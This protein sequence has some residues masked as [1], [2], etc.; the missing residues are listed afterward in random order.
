MDFSNH[1]VL[2]TGASRGVGAATARAFAQAGAK[3]VYLAARNTENLHK[4]QSEIEAMG[5]CA[6]AFTVDL[7]TREACRELAAK[8]GDIDVLVN[9]AAFTSGAD[10]NVLV[11][12]DEFWDLNFAVTF[13]APLTLMQEFG[14]GM[15]QRGYGVVLNISSMAAQRPVPEYAPYG[16]SK[17]AL[18]VLSK[19]A[20]ME[21]A[22]K[23]VRVNSIA[24]GHVDTE[25]LQENCGEGLTPDDVARVNSPLG[26]AIKAS[27]IA[28]FCV[29]LASDAAA[30]IVGTV[31]TIDGGLTS[32]SYSFSKTFGEQTRR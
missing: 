5:G 29:Y 28:D 13:W 4:V 27:E 2:V 11:R 1:R 10:Q 9:N 23:G 21:L 31:L 26:R 22:G 18:D 19:A 25:A 12:N 30:P 24:L 32:G 6:E 7:S 14:R 20:G 3:K 15:E 17:G 8:V 16:V